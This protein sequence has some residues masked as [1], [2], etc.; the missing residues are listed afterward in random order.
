LLSDEITRR[1]SLPLNIA[2]A[3]P[4]AILRPWRCLSTLRESAGAVVETLAAGL[5]PTTATPLNTDI[6]PYRRFDWTTTDVSKVKEI[7]NQFSGKLN[8]VVLSVTAGAVRRFL[9]QRGLRVTPD[10]VFRVMVP[11]SIRNVSERGEPGNRVVNF[12]ARLP[13]HIEDPVER[14]TAT[15]D[16]TSKLKS[17]RLVRG[18][19]VIEEIGDRTFTSVVVQFVRLAA[20]TRA[21]NLVV[22]NVPGPPVPIY[23]LGAKMTAIYPLVPLFRQQ[24]L[25]IALFSYDGRL[26]WGF[27]SDWETIPDLHDFAAT[28][29]QEIEGLLD[30]ARQHA[31]AGRS[32]R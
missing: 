20:V 14:L 27:N 25:G 32:P 17:S 12:L 13:V 6:G 19:E 31:A 8:D 3:T 4:G 18:A 10:T 2:L 24:G 7:R 16:V 11:V 21:Y 5:S 22:T 9:I 1:A 29:D 15:V 28:V 26:Y 23:F 30:R